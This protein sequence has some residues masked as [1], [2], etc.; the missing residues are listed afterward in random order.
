MKSLLEMAN[1]NDTKSFSNKLRQER[2]KKFSEN[3]ET[4]PR[5]VKILDVGGTERF[6]QLRGW[7]DLDDVN[8]VII[9]LKA[10][11]TQSKNIVVMAGDARDLSQFV[12]DSFDVAFSNSVIE[13]LFDW[14][15]QKQMAKEMQR[16]ARV[17]WVQTPN[18]WFPIEPHFL[19]PAW[20]WLPRKWRIRM[21]ERFRLGNRGPCKSYEDAARLVDEIR[22]LSARE[23]QE[24][25]PGATIWHEKFFGLSKSITAY[26][27][28]GA[29]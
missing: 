7:A 12:D 23:M 15:S 27:G 13:H 18:Y 21:I 10:L 2:F 9:N 20:Q 26:G 25:F 28:F 17:Y 14:Q 3:V 19:F 8:I 4:L 11:E 5:P 16:V 22:L 6:W 24:L 29:V 1:A